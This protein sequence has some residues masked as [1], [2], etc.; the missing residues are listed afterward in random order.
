MIFAVMSNC[1]ASL[2]SI[3]PNR[4]RRTCLL[5]A[6]FVCL[7][8]SAVLAQPAPQSPAQQPAA[9]DAQD[10]PLQTLK[11]DVSVVNLF[12]NV[13][14]NHGALIPALTKYM[15]PTDP[16]AKKG[17][18]VVLLG[19][20]GADRQRGNQMV[21]FGSVMR[22]P[23]NITA[24]P[25]FPGSVVVLAGFVIWM[26]RNRT[27]SEERTSATGNPSTITSTTSR[28]TQIGISNKGS[29][30]E[31]PWASAQPPTK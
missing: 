3:F 11:V 23:R 30:W 12:F 14:D 13:H 1:T 29:S 20:T 4:L 2:P 22:W 27:V 25:Y 15:S 17:K 6:A 16:K 8:V 31:R 7:L 21:M 26:S 5:A 24:L 9:A 18:L 19:P 28:T 10:Q